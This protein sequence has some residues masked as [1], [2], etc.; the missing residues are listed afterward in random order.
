MDINIIWDLDDV[1]NDLNYTVYNE[2]GIADILERQTEYSIRKNLESG[3]FDEKTAKEIL[4]MYSDG[5]LFKR[6]P[7][8]GNIQ[9]ILR[10]KQMNGL[11]EHNI[12][13]YINTFSLNKQVEAGKRIWLADNIKNLSDITL[14]F[15]TGTPKP[16]VANATFVVD[17]CIDELIKYGSDTVKI[18][19]DMP[20]NRGIDL[21][22]AASAGHKFVRVQSLPEAV[23]Y[24]EREVAKLCKS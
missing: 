9:S 12:N 7:T 22:L 3:L 20:Y 2:L 1:L 19:M 16:K 21:K 14:I 15:N 18:I 24:I 6:L 10:V 4:D 5:E 8:K 13:V 11:N 17:D 23:Q